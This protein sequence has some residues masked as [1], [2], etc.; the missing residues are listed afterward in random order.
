VVDSRAEPSKIFSVAAVIALAAAD[1]A[2]AAVIGSGAED[3]A[4]FAAAGD[5]EN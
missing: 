3:L 1:L 2:E 5:D 4:V